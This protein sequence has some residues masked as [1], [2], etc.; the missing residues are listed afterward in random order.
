[1]LTHT[2][3]KLYACGVCGQRLSCSIVVRKHEL[4]HTGEKP[5]VCGVCGQRFSASRH[6]KAHEW[7]HTGDVARMRAAL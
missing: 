4:T 5:Y 2:G 7:T 1:M 6:M 3:E